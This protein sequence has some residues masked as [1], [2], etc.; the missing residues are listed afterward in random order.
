MWT[1]FLCLSDDIQENLKNDTTKYLRSEQYAI[2]G[3]TATFNLTTYSTHSVC[4]FNYHLDIV[5]SAV[6]S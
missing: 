3:P 2:L 5:L 4:H 1:S 6:D